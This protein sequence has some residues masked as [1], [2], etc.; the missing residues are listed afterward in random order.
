MVTWVIDIECSVLVEEITL[1]SKAAVNVAILEI[2][3]CVAVMLNVRDFITATV[4]NGP[5]VD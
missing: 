4:T 3:G 1:C 2:D 5:M